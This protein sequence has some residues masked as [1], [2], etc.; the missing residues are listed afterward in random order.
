MREL[1]HT[2]IGGTAGNTDQPVPAADPLSGLIVPV[3]R[4][5]V[6]TANSL[7]H[8]SGTMATDWAKAVG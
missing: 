6:M 5:A 7:N 1:G 4:F 2:S 8:S 3:D